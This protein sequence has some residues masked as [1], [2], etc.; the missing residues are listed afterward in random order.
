MLV[1]YR[2]AG[3]V[4]DRASFRG[5]LFKSAHNHLCGHY[6][7]LTREVETVNLADADNRLAL[8][9]HK[10]AG[11][12]AFEF[13]DW[14]AILDAQERDVMG[15]AEYTASR[16]CLETRT[17]EDIAEIHSLKKRCRRSIGNVEIQVSCQ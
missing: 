14:M 16:S 9:T 5:W 17:A 10:P 6:G 3:Q 8:S 12:P 2:K 4:R 1:V 13:R 7:R 15:I 11:T